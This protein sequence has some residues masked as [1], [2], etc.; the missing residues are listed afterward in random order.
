MSA[1]LIDGKTIAA[2]IRDEV[3]AAVREMVAE[4]KPAPGLATV[5]VGN[6]PASETYVRSKHRA[7]EQSGI[8]SFGHELPAETS[9]QDVEALI[10]K[11]NQDHRVHGILVQLP[12]PHHL[13]EARIL[14]LVSPEKDVDGF[15]PYNIG[16]LAMKGREPLFVPCT[17]AGVM[18]LL[19]SV[20]GKLDGETGGCDRPLKYCRYASRLIAFT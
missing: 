7:C 5:L 12:L 1:L 6:D 11:L 20:Y 15:H 10:V 14:S 9:Q 17:P 16:A 4:G 19:R 3:G 8:I 2:G 13:D 18:V